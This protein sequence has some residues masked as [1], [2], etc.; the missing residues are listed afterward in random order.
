MKKY[1]FAILFT[2]LGTGAKAQ[3]WTTTTT[4]LENDVSIVYHELDSIV[5]TVM[6]AGNTIVTVQPAEAPEDGLVHDMTL[7]LLNGTTVTYEAA[8]LDSVRY[9][10]GVGMKVYVTGSTTSVDYLYSQMTKIVYSTGGSTPPIDNN[11]NANWNITGYNI[12]E[13]GINA[14]TSSATYNMAWRLE[15][16]QIR[17]DNNSTVIVHAS[18][19][20]GIS[21]SLELDKSQRANRWSCFTMHAGTPDN[22][23][24]RSKDKFSNESLVESRY[25][26][27]TQEYT[28]G[29][30]TKSTTNLDGSTT[31]L[32]AR[33]HICASDDRQS[34]ATQN[35]FTF[36]T[37]NCHPQY[38]AHNAG[39]WSRIETKVKSWGYNNNFRDT[40][41]VAKGATISNVTLDGITKTGTIPNSEIYSK[42]GINITGSLVI[43]R[44]WYMAIL[45]LK[46]GEYHAMAFWTEQINSSCSSTTI[47]SCMITIDELETRTGIDFFCNLPD[48]IEATVEAT[49]D[50]NFWNVN[51]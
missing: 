20:Y 13:S 22:N 14:T 15:Y 45:C 10:P 18:S 19:D 48:D 27:D 24:G 33:G 5:P 16:P 25:Q 47:Q 34:S 38:Q 51:N 1:I 12:P 11:M 35:G 8:D 43:P 9:L 31:T 44:Y 28:D 49:V 37:S 39:L 46:N 36:L 6:T 41:Y 7:Y 17:A 42:F 3:E 30:Y 26:V 50:N 2:V 4:D 32:L 23:V 21:Y 40:L 29:N